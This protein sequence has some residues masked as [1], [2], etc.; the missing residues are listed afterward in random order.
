MVQF[1]DE[2]KVQPAGTQYLGLI[3]SLIDLFENPEVSDVVVVFI[4][5]KL[6][7]EGERIVRDG[8]NVAQIRPIGIYSIDDDVKAEL[9]KQHDVAPLL[10]L[11][12]LWRRRNATQTDPEGKLGILQF[13][14][15]GL[16]END[17]EPWEREAISYYL[18]RI[19]GK[20]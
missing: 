1:G 17:Y 7:D 10:S 13:R 3:D 15:V 6:D 19:A 4:S 8:Q 12:V 2:G 16:A 9:K 5:F 14:P 20:N 11:L 18:H